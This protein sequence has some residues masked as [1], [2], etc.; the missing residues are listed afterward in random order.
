MLWKL[1]LTKTDNTFYRRR[2]DVQW[3]GAGEPN[4]NPGK[5][6]NSGVVMG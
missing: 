4:G 3:S 2:M 5:R 1:P 6:E